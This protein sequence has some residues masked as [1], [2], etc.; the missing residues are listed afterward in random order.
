MKLI[1][2]SS[3]IRDFGIKACWFEL[4]APIDSRNDLITLS[5]VPCHC[6][7]TRTAPPPLQPG[8]RSLWSSRLPNSNATEISCQTL[9]IQSCL[10]EVASPEAS[11]IQA[12]LPGAFVGETFI[13]SFR[14]EGIEVAHYTRIPIRSSEAFYRCKYVLVSTRAVHFN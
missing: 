12:V 9:D 8:R 1:I 2:L 11:R 6:A 5:S 4:W 7:T 13:I 3:M 10:S 14:G